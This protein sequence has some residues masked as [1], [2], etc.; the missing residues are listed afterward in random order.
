MMRGQSF[1]YIKALYEIP[2]VDLW[3]ASSETGVYVLTS[4]NKVYCGFGTTLSTRLP[5]TIQKQE[6]GELIFFFP[7]E[8][9]NLP[10]GASDTEFAKFIEANTIAALNT[11]IYGNGLPFRLT[12]IDHATW[13]PKAA[14]AEKTTNEYK[15]PVEIAQTVIGR[16]GVPSHMTKLPWYEIYQTPLPRLILDANKAAW[17]AILAAEATSRT[18]KGN[19]DYPLRV[20]HPA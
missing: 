17:P 20:I 9:W 3:A 14:W 6:F 1:Q 13:L 4:F 10:E 8:L 5:K 15:L 7:A 16:I 2:L 19:S 18:A 12:N 11:I